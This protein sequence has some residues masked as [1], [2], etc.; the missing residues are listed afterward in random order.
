MTLLL[1]PLLWLRTLM[2]L[3]GTAQ[4]HLGGHEGTDLLH[5]AAKSGLMGG[6]VRANEAAFLASSSLLRGAGRWVT[7]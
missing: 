6:V 1:R 3:L 4:G 5:Y 7:D 2:L